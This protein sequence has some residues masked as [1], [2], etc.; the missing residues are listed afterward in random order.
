MPLSL[1]EIKAYIQEPQNSEF[2]KEANRI[3]R[4]HELHVNGMHVTKWLDKIEGIEN[5]DYISLREA[6]AL[7]ITVPESNRIIT[8]ENKVFTARGGGR[9]YDFTNDRDKEEFRE[10]LKDVRKGLSMHSF[11][12]KDWK[13]YVNY[14]SS[15]ILLVEINPEDESL[16]I[17]YKSSEY[18]HDVSY[19]SAQEIDYIIFKPYTDEQGYQ[20]Y[21][22]IDD[23][24]DY[25]IK[26][27][28]GVY[29]IDEDNTFENIWGFVPGTF[30]SDRI[31]K[32]E[33]AFDTHIS[34]AMIYA[35]SLLLD[36]T[37]YRIYKIKQGI[38]FVWQYQRACSNCN[39]SGYV[40]KSEGTTCGSCSGKGY[41]NINRAASE[42]IT[43]PMPEEGEPSIIPPA[44]YVQPDLET[45]RQFETTMQGEKEKMYSSVW[46]EISVIDRQRNNIT[47]R[48]VEIRENSKESKLNDISD[49]AEKVE[50]RLTDIFA[51]FY[52]PGSY[53][54]SIINY[55]RDYYTK[56]SDELIMEY[57]DGLQKSLP[58]TE[59][60]NILERYYHT[61]YSR[62]PQKLNE[63]IINLKA[64]PFYHW[65]PE[66]LLSM[67]V[68]QEDYLKNLY[69]DEFKVWYEKN[70][71][72]FG[73]S[74]L[75]E[76][77]AELD[78]WIVEK[79]PQDINTNIEQDE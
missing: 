60:T 57:E 31:D 59:L 2:I 73:V 6:L 13:R 38:P 76:V 72:M 42:L 34:E 10:I 56:S 37:I 23:S 55:G 63:S 29:S 19:K 74:T 14:D 28:N 44:G 45:W 51:L 43:L 41:D 18:L 36:H 24:Y 62:S 4:K 61:L 5:D 77:Q 32:K 11:M 71:K 67:N 3:R 7:P 58:S 69:F 21:R 30:I 47:A 22:V 16:Y 15:G 12:Q 46:G 17:T 70:K 52:F 35:D 50:K 75:D 39:G 53:E 79:I 49:N 68:A 40:D 48:E 66:R 54:G 1:E 25:L 26:E 27:K 65:S 20:V 8:A 9:F 78:K 64:K 33:K